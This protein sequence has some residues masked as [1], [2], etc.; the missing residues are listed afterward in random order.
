[1][2]DISLLHELKDGNREA[3]NGV[4]RYYYPRMMAYVASMVE[5][6]VA[7]DIVQ[8]VFLY[9][10]ENREKLYV[11]DGFHSYLFQSA[12]TRCLDYFKKNHLV[13]K[14]HSHTFEQYL[15]DCH[16]LLKDDN[17]IIEELSVKEFYCRLYELLEYLP[18]QRREVFILAYI[19]GLTTK[20]VAEQTRMPQRTVESH[21]YLALRFLKEHMHKG[22]FYLLT[23]L[24]CQAGY[25]NYI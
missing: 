3:F 9:V 22:D 8:D 23:L 18:E 13:E 4:F 14:C 20:E 6:K 11:S 25:K 12:Y 15:E 1:M 10:W 7:E 21:V 24:L 17:S 5:Q 19:K 2:F 16:D